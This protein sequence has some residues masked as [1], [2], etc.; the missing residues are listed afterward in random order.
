MESWQRVQLNAG[1]YLITIRYYYCRNGGEFPAVNIDG[2][3][4]INSCTIQEELQ[5]YPECLERI[6]NYST[7]FYLCLHY[8]VYFILLRQKLF[9]NSF[10][11]REFLPV[12]NTET[13]FFYG[14]LKKGETIKIDITQRLLTHSLVFFTFYNRGSF[15]VCWEEITQKVY[16]SQQM[17][18]SGYY[19][20]RVHGTIK[21]EKEV[22]LQVRITIHR[23]I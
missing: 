17:P 15:P 11:K 3:S 22:R 8:Y 5:S 6:R 1:T 9:V 12:G 14:I 21:Q 10:V 19:L 16:R 7:L 13:T 4:S 23:G 18:C 20:L 2:L